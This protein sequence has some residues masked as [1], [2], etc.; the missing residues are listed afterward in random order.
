MTNPPTRLIPVISPV[1]IGLLFDELPAVPRI[2]LGNDSGVEVRV[3]AHLFAGHGIQGEPGR[4]FSHASRALGDDDEIDD[5]QDDENN[6]ADHEIALNDK[7]AEGGDEIARVALRE[8]GAG[9]GDVQPEAKQRDEEQQGR[10][11]TEIGG[12]FDVGDQHDD[13]HR[14]RDAQAEQH[15]DHPG[16]QRQDQDEDNPDHSH[17][18]EQVAPADELLPTKSMLIHQSFSSLKISLRS[19]SETPVF[20]GLV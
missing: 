3:D 11:N 5:G 14:N 16:R 15:V 6:Q 8:D 4:D 19:A 10:K 12:P 13:Q 1:K 2:A 7:L 20:A 9:R 17:A 18:E